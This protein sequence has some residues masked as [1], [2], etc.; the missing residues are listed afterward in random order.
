[1]RSFGGDDAAHAIVAEETLQS[2]S[3]A[4]TYSEKLPVRN[5]GGLYKTKRFCALRLL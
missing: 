5:A 1:V 3:N 4:R 2:P